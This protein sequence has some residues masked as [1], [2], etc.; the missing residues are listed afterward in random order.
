MVVGYYH[1]LKKHIIQKQWIKVDIQEIKDPNHEIEF[2]ESAVEYN[3]CPHCNSEQQVTYVEYAASCGSYLLILV[4]WYWMG[5]LGL[6]TTPM[7]WPAF[8]DVVHRCSVCHNILAR[9][10]RIRCP[11]VTSEVFSIQFGSCAIVLSKKYLY[12]FFC[13]MGFLIFCLMFRNSSIFHQSLLRFDKVGERIEGLSWEGFIKDC[14][15]DPRREQFLAQHEELADLPPNHPA[16]RSSLGGNPLRA[17]HHFESTYVGKSIVWEGKLVEIREGFN[18][19]YL[20]DA[21]GMLLLN[22]DDPSN[23]RER[24]G[25]ISSALEELFF[26]GMQEMEDHEKNNKVDLAL[27]FKYP[28]S[29][30]ERQIG[31][32]QIND[33][34]RF[35][36]TFAGLG[37]RGNPHVFQLW[38]IQ[39]TEM[40]RPPQ[41]IRIIRSGGPMIFGGGLDSLFGGGGF[42]GGGGLLGGGGDDEDRPQRVVIRMGTRTIVNGQEVSPEDAPP[43]PLE[44]LLGGMGGGIPHRNQDE[45]EGEG[46]ELPSGGKDEGSA[47]GN[48]EKDA[49]ANKAPEFI[50][51]ESEVNKPPSGGDNAE[52]G[53][54]TANKPAEGGDETLFP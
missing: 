23:P 12:A 30:I 24:S 31:E 42:F 40:P 16:R 43:N 19:L 45:P 5:Y 41:R 44:S 14:G 18:I 4:W 37:K 1:A 21:P 11:E 46:G 32:L 39:K 35:E 48:N 6:I 8:K 15:V 7:L 54:E 26:P 22:M 17:K 38:K 2:G 10:P 3:V 36:A 47:S 28:D 52:G 33:W 27:L 34:V 51:G 29:E 53:D 20:W 9:K 13:F 49:E 50:P 25:G